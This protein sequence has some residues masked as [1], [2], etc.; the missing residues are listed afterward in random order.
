MLLNHHLLWWFDWLWFEHRINPQWVLWIWNSAPTTD[1]W[2]I[3]GKTLIFPFPVSL[4]V[5]WGSRCPSAI[6]QH[7]K[8]VIDCQSHVFSLSL[9]VSMLWT[10]EIQC[11]ISGGKKGYPVDGKLY[12]I[13]Y[14]CFPLGHI[15]SCSYLH[16]STY[17]VL[18]SLKK[19][20]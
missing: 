9:W 18:Q 14:F 4:P 6:N 13:D 19:T 10:L 8:A 15:V 17:T 11:F 3:L 2:G 1:C 7:S 20:Y 5:G 16:F 12:R